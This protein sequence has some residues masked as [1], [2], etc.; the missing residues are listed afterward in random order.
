[1]KQILLKNFS[2]SILLL[3]LACTTKTKKI[4][5]AAYTIPLKEELTSQNILREYNSLLDIQSVIPLETNRLSIVRTIDK[6]VAHDTLYYILDRTSN[7]LFRFSKTGSFIDSFSPKDY[8]PI[9]DF[10]IADSNIVAYSHENDVL[11]FLN[12]NLKPFSRKNLNFKFHSFAFNEDSGH[13]IFDIGYNF[14]SNLNDH[15]LIITDSDFNILSSAHKNSSMI[16]WFLDSSDGFGKLQSN[17]F[18]NNLLY[19]LPYFSNTLYSIDPDGNILPE[20]SIDFGDNF[21]DADRML[22]YEHELG[23]PSDIYS[24]RNLAHSLGYSSTPN[25]L[26]LSFNLN[27]L[28]YHYFFDK[29]TKKGKL[30]EAPKDLSCGCGTLLTY[31]GFDDESLILTVNQQKLPSFLKALNLEE[32]SVLKDSEIGALNNPVLFLA[33]IK[34]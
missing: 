34:L 14:N 20:V 31:K 10:I 18:Y 3:T 16:S 11:I 13:Y 30:V 19:Y 23:S 9:S 21:L 33:N 17:S 1:M 24:I 5:D 15:Q 32:K 8:S 25:H 28:T 7:Q 29:S 2:Y 26:V 27:N 4:E 22:K 12:E 6:I